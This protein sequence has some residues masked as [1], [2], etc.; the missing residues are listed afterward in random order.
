MRIIKLLSLAHSQIYCKIIICVP[1]G[2]EVKVLRQDNAE[3]E[4]LF[5][6]SEGP[7]NEK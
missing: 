1:S 4:V 7:T 5:F 3:K 6:F 2:K